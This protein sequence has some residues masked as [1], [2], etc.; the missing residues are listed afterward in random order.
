MAVV[1]EKRKGVDALPDTY[2]AWE[3][4][5]AGFENVGRGGA[6]TELPLRPPADNEVLL[7]VD[8]IGLCLSDIKII[9]LGNDKL[10]ALR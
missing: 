4:Y 7:R 6:P 2:L 3:L 5:G 1:T 8:A 10:V 9:K